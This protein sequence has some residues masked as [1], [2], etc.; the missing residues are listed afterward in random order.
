MTWEILNILNLTFMIESQIQDSYLILD[1][2]LI[3]S[4]WH[5]LMDEKG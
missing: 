4:F 1:T 3:L 5:F 2:H